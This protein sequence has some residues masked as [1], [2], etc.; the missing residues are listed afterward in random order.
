M[1]TFIR[2]AIARA[3]RKTPR[4]V[5]REHMESLRAK[6]PTPKRVRPRRPVTPDGKMLCPL[7]LNPVPL[8]EFYVHRP[9]DSGY[10]HYD[11]HCNSCRK[12][13]M[14]ARRVGIGVAEYDR[15]IE[16]SGGLCAL[17]RRPYGDRPNIDHSHRTGKIRGVLCSRCNTGIGLFL[18]SAELLNAAILYLRSS[19]SD[20]PRG[21]GPSVDQ[22]DS[23]NDVG[24]HHA[25]QSDAQQPTSPGVNR[26]DESRNH[27][28]YQGENQQDQR[29]HKGSFG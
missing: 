24:S 3:K 15:L 1:K 17:C 6:R 29:K 22:R 12:K 28:K 23:Q 9:K 10:S 20:L 8:S 5:T 18:D 11:M 26:I 25:G 27:E 2:E 4:Y 21:S 13:W 16:A 14:K 7:C 19:A